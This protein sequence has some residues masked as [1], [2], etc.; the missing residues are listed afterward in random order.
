MPATALL[1][2][3]APGHLVEVGDVAGQRVVHGLDC[4][5]GGLAVAVR[6]PLDGTLPGQRS[7]L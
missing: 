4:R 2:V 3:A 6:L 1:P 5:H 7:L